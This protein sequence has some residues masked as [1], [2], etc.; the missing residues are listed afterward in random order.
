MISY[1]ENLYYNPEALGYEIVEVIDLD[2]EAWQFYML[3][4]WRDPD[5]NLVYQIDSGCSCPSPFEDMTPESLLQ[6]DYNEVA[7]YARSVYSYES[8]KMHI[9]DK[10]ARLRR[11]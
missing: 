5:G 2:D 11:L 1:E 6:F 4:V 10:L 3:V 9:E 8:M 7:E